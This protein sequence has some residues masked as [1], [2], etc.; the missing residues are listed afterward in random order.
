M[1]EVAS[2]TD[3]SK[4]NGGYLIAP[5][6][7]DIP[8]KFPML[9]QVPRLSDP[10][11]SCIDLEIEKGFHPVILGLGDIIIPGYGIGL[12]VTFIALT[13]METAQPALIY[14]I[15]F[16]LGPIIILA[17]IRKEFKL[18]WTGNFSKSENSHVPRNSATN[19]ANNDPNF[20][21]NDVVPFTVIPLPTTSP[22]NADRREI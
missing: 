9:F 20:G 6:N 22:S 11:I 4:A 10:M 5:I 17:L 21:S 16:T 7:T 18:L 2:G 13:L 12:I 15:P 8:E 14:L 19:I 1:I 3:C